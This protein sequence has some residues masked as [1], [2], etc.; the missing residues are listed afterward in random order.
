MPTATKVNSS[1]LDDLLKEVSNKLRRPTAKQ[2]ERASVTR[3]IVK[4]ETARQ[5]TNASRVQAS[6]ARATA[7][8][9]PIL[10]RAVAAERTAAARTSQSEARSQQRITEIGVRQ[11]AR[12]TNRQ[13]E[14]AYAQALGEERAAN[15]S[16]REYGVT[17]A[18]ANARQDIAREQL[19]ARVGGALGGAV[20]KSG[21]SQAVFGTI[22]SLI[23]AGAV[24]IILY[25]LLNNSAGVQGTSNSAL[26]FVMALTSTD[27]LFTKNSSNTTASNTSP[28]STKGNAGQ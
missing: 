16:L 1:E 25:L 3:N 20:I 19:P 11:E 10:A 9:A 6:R 17:R 14:L 28:N 23:A 13:Q 27:P 12:E 5:T 8:R 15:A 18:R 24:A 21:P 22:G 7:A 2:K 26:N 4:R